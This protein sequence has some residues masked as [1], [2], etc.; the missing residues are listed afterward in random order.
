MH[1]HTNMAA[2]PAELPDKLQTP[3]N[4]SVSRWAELKLNDRSN[5]Q[6]LRVLSEEQ[7]QFWKENGYVIIPNAVPAQQIEAVVNL[8]WEF[9]EKSPDEPSAWYRPPRREIQMK[10]LVNS[11]MVELY[12]HQA[13][14]NNRQHPRVYD[15][16]VD[17][18]GVEKLW[19]TIDRANL[20]FPVRPGHEFKGFIHWDIDT[21]LDPKPVNVQGVLSLND[22]TEDMGGFQCIPELYRRFGEWVKTQ[23]ADRNPFQPDTTGFKI[24][25]VPTKAGDLLVW[26]SMLAHGIRPNHSNKP[27]LA[28]YIS[29]APA[30]PERQDLLEWRISSWRDRV[31]P[32]GYPFPGDPRKWEQ[33]HAETAQLTELGEKL[34]GLKPWQ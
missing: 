24:E 25:K 3:G 23:P 8:I 29:M 13:L 22:T 30:Q 26:D 33:T 28:Q 1:Q 7:W 20:N 21:S 10:E 15:A 2:S 12:N 17:I 34:L 32:E 19:V 18:W 9:E 6:S 16:F 31:A 4:P 27:R 11:G 5:G 14:W